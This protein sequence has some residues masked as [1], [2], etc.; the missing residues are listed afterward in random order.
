MNE[1]ITSRILAALSAFVL[2]IVLILGL[3]ATGEDI[4]QGQHVRLLFVHPGVAWT[5]YVAFS[6]TT[7]ASLLWLWPKTRKPFWDQVAGASTEIGVVFTVLALVTG[8][9]WGRPTWGTWW[10]WDARITSTTL[11]LFMY[12]GVLAVRR[13]P[14]SPDSLARRSAIVALIAFLDVPIVHFSVKWWRT[15]HQEASL[16]KPEKPSVQGWQLVALILSF[17]GFTFL[18]FWMLIQRY[19]I[20]RWESR[21][22][23]DALETAITQRRAEAT[24]TK[25][26]NETVGAATAPTPTAGVSS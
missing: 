8:A 16:L 21:L 20:A 5:A 10:V 2:G 13:V 17:F 3:F 23:H 26:E 15:L 9:I 22:E 25:I 19:R 4:V 14:S 11:L 6:I 18:Y 24:R 1:Q 12:L 7:A